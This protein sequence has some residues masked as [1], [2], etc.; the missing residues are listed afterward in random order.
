M[1]SCAGYTGTVS[2]MDVVVVPDMR[3]YE[4]LFS[5]DADANDI[6]FSFSKQ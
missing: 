5:A 4:D 3:Q 6:L 1:L 2:F